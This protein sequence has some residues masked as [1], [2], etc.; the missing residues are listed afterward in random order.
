MN[1]A[2]F[3][4]AAEPANKSAE[5]HSGSKPRKS[6]DVDMILQQPSSPQGISECVLYNCFSTTLVDHGQEQ[7]LDLDTYLLVVQQSTTLGRLIQKL[8]QRDYSIAELTFAV[9]KMLRWT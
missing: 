5:G 8:K 7:L 6:S 3:L 2:D 9:N 1:T 4:F